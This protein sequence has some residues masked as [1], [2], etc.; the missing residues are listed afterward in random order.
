MVSAATR[1]RSSASEAFNA[2]STSSSADWSRAIAYSVSTCSLAG[3][4]RDSRGGPS[5]CQRHAERPGPTTG[6]ATTTPAPTPSGPLPPEPANPYDDRTPVLGNFDEQHW[7]TSVS[8][9]SQASGY[10]D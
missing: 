8:A 3:S 10:A 1:I 6:C 5:T 7:G 2:S 4:R 9:I